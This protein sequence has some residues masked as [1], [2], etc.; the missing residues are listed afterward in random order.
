MQLSQ[1]LHLHPCILTTL[2]LGL[3]AIRTDTT[4][5]EI[6]EDILLQ[7]WIPVCQQT[8]LGWE[9]LYH[10]CLSK[11]WATAINAT[12]PHLDRSGEQVLVLMQKQIWKYVLATWSKRNQHLHNQA[13]N[14]NLPDYQQA[15]SAFTNS[16]TDYPQQHKKPFTDSP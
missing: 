9:Q 2:W 13:A 11:T 12:H 8:R 1:K 6:S 3:T 15:R 5:P 14:L 7:L 10:G 4:H 16:N